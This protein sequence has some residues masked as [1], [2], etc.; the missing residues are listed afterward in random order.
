MAGVRTIGPKRAL[1]NT[2]Q[3]RWAQ[4]FPRTGGVLYAEAK[5]N[6]PQRSRKAEQR[7]R[8]ERRTWFEA[9]IMFTIR[10][11][12]RAC[13]LLAAIGVCATAPLSARAQVAP[14]ATVDATKQAAPSGSF[15]AMRQ[16]GQVLR[17]RS[18]TAPSGAPAGTVALEFE[19]GVDL[20]DD[21]QITAVYDSTGD[22]LA[23]QMIA[24]E[25]RD[26]RPLWHTI[27]V[28]YPTPHSEQGVQ[29]AS[30]AG[31]APAAGQQP[32]DLSA[33]TLARA[34]TLSKWLWNHRCRAAD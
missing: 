7:L 14:S 6:A 34:R 22:P 33:D 5:N 2:L 17:C 1:G 23:L 10:T 29:Y 4:P 31:S 13:L 20:V 32:E 28:A 15:D 27:V 3:Q 11:A 9:H 21:R 12:I 16:P 26:G 30:A 8:C 19:D 24:T 18:V 25:K